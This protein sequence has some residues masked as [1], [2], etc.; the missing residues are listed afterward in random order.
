[1]SNPLPHSPPVIPTPPGVVPSTVW[2]GLRVMP[3]PSRSG[4]TNAWL[5]S[6]LK[7]SVGRGRSLDR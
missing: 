3:W 4:A 1:M 2:E 7:P 5:I 6:A